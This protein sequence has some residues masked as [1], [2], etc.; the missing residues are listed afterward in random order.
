MGAKEDIIREIRDARGSIPEGADTTLIAYPVG[1]Y[2]GIQLADVV[3]SLNTNG[4]SAAF[5][6]AQI[7]SILQSQQESSGNQLEALGLIASLLMP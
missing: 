7:R 3:G 1:T 4:E 2:P 6:L 5:I